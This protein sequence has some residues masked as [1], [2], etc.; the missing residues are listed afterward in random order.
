MSAARVF[1][2]VG[3][4]VLTTLAWMALGLTIVQRTRAGYKN[5]GPQVE[6][7]WGEPLVQLQ[8]TVKMLVPA[9]TEHAGGTTAQPVDLSASNISTDLKLDYRRKGLLWFPGYVVAFDGTYT[10][11]NPAKERRRFVVEFTYPSDK[12]NYDEAIFT[13]DGKDNQEFTPT[14]ATSAVFIDPGQSAKV[15][16][17]YK[18]RGMGRWSY[19]F[20]PGIQNVRDFAL[21]ITTDFPNYDFPSGT[22]SPREQKATASGAE[23]RWQS[24]MLR[25]SFTV[26]V[27]MPSKV[28][29]GEVASRIAFF[30]PVGLF[31]FFVVMTVWCLMR[32]INLHPMHYLFLAAGFFAFHLLFAYLVDLV[33]IFN[34]FLIAALASVLLVVN[35]MRLVTGLRFALAPTGL[36]QLIYLILFSYAFFFRGFTGLAVTVGAVITLAVLMQVTAKVDWERAF[37]PRTAPTGGAEPPA[38]EPA[39]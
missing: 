35:Y 9:G 32:G 12:A 33:N 31:F 26:G 13:I 8:P 30:A 37:S 38:V 36:A 17:G 15:H 4:F 24:G 34:A 16:V 20:G 2:V 7:L 3:I 29:P 27:A 11:T 5:I 1:A 23:L 19:A 25:S 10:V 18:T 6:N 14:G 21:L 22:I 28:N 39:K